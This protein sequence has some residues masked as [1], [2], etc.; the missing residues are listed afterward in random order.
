LTLG[1]W[2]C[3]RSGDAPRF[4]AIAA[5]QRKLIEML[6]QWPVPWSLKIIAEYRGL[7]AAEFPLPLSARRREQMASFRAAFAAWWAA[8]R[9]DVESAIQSPALP[10]R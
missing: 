3:G 8:A 1:L 2:K 4:A 6:D 10:G 9:L 5:H 7:A